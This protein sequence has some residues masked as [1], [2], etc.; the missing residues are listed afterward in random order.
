[1]WLDLPFFSNVSGC[2]TKRAHN[3]L[4]PKSSL[5]IQTTTALGMFKDSAIILDAIRRSLLTKSATAA[6][7]I[8]L[9]LCTYDKFYWIKPSLHNTTDSCILQL[10]ISATCFGLA[11]PSLRTIAFRHPRKTGSSV[12]TPTE[13]NPFPLTLLLGCYQYT[14]F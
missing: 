3:F 11:W 9:L 6:I 8:W 1:M 4:F 2:G 14:T 10:V 13:L 5:G 7:W 12:S